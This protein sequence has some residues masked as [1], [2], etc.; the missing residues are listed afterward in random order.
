MF[1]NIQLSQSAEINLKFALLWQRIAEPVIQSMNS[2]DHQNIVFIQLQKI[3]FI[4][5]GSCFEI[6]KPASLTL[7][8]SKSSSIS[9][10]NCSTSIASRHSKFL[11]PKLIYRSQVPVNEIIIHCDRMRFHSMGSQLNRQPV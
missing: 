11:F 8:P 4:F 10:L 9:L 7:F 6:R 2:L 3:T 5:S 1:I